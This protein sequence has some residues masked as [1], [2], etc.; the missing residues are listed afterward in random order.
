MS[1]SKITKLTFDRITRYPFCNVNCMMKGKPRRTQCDKCPFIDYPFDYPFDY[2]KR[3][4]YPTF[5]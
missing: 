3:R 5:I 4:Y 1:K 2:P